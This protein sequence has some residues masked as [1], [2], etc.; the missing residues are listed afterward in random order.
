MIGQKVTELKT[1][2]PEHHGNHVNY[3]KNPYKHDTFN[4]GDQGNQG[5]QG[6]QATKEPMY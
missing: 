5:N 6:N 4:L 2:Q 1:R 3:E